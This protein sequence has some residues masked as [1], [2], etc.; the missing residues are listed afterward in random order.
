MLSPGKKTYNNHYSQNPLATQS[1]FLYHPSH[2]R[3]SRPQRTECD[4]RAGCRV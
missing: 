4:A 2:P 1:C 3:A